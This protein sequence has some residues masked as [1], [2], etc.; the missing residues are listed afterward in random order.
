MRRIVASIR[1]DSSAVLGGL[2]L[3]AERHGR[4]AASCGPACRRNAP[5]HPCRRASVTDP[6]IRWRVTFYRCD[7]TRVTEGTSLQLT[8]R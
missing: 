8:R 2:M 6:D 5:S 1:K 3:N 7:A 4:G